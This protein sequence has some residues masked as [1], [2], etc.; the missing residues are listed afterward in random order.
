[1]Y[2]CG[3][4]SKNSYTINDVMAASVDKLSGYHMHRKNHTMTSLIEEAVKGHAKGKWVGGVGHLI[5]QNKIDT[6]YS[7]CITLS[8]CI[9]FENDHP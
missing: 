5:N 9:H 4:D 1:M 2:I 8:V 7:Y 3:E 6:S